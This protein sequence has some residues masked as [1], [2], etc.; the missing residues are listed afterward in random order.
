MSGKILVLAA[1]V[2]L[3]AS[4]SLASAQTLTYPGYWSG[5]YGGFY[6]REFP[7]GD[8]LVP[9]GYVPA[10]RIYGYAPAYNPWAPAR[11]GW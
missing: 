2:G 11:Y 6:G 3:L 8:G 10:P 1:A 9:Y 4:T 7:L 5:G